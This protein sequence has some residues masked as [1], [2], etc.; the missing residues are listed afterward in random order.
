VID[1]DL[2]EA[3]DSEYP[4]LVQGGVELGQSD[5]GDAFFYFEG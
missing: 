2:A 1:A 3:S 5:E 4:E